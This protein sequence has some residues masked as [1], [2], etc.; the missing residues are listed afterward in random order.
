MT[1]ELTNDEKVQIIEQH[2]KNLIYAR[3]NTALNLKE[4]QAVA[5]PEQSTIDSLNLQISDLD[6]K[7]AVLESEL[8]KLQVEVTAPPT[9]K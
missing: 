2:L 8:A 9:S 7:Q 1:L 4:N 5:T 6:A 3:Y